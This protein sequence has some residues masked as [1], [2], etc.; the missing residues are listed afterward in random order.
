[1]GVIVSRFEPR[2][3]PGT[4]GTRDIRDVLMTNGVLKQDVTTIA[5]SQTR[6]PLN[7][8]ISC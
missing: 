7:I 5:S 6:N 8:H 3:G 4:A 1:M 2:Q